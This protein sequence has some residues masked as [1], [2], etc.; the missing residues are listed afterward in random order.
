MR[1]N[2]RKFHSGLTLTELTV[3]MVIAMIISLAVGVLLASGQRSW[4]QTYNT[5]HKQIRED[6]QAVMVRFGSMGRKSNRL[7]YTLYKV[8]GSTFIPAEPESSDET[9]VFG[10]AVEFR[11]WD[12]E[13]DRADSHQ[14]MDVTKT[15]TAY[16]LFYVDGDK[17]KVDYGPYPPGAVPAGVGSRNTHHVTTTVLAESVISNPA[18]RPFSHTALGGAGQGSVRINI[19]LKDPEDDDSVRIMT[20]TLMRNIWPR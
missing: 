1:P 19:T 16:A 6:A 8:I 4:N 17:L 15:A 5:T 12:V 9:V 10:D 11:F 3:A 2:I 13:L 7:G 20:A 14:L 18:A